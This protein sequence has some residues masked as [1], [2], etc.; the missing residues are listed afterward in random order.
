[1]LVAQESSLN[2]GGVRAPPPAR[3]ELD[4]PSDQEGRNGMA[5]PGAERAPRVSRPGQTP[6]EANVGPRSEQTKADP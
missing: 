2:F 3:H 1:M 6:D 4:D 5:L